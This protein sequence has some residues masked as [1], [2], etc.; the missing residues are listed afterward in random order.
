MGYTVFSIG[1]VLGLAAIGLVVIGLLAP[2]L[3]VVSGVDLGSRHRK[4][5]SQEGV[6][7]S[8][9]RIVLFWSDGQFSVRDGGAVL[10]DQRVISYEAQEDGELW[11]RAAAYEDIL[12]VQIQQD[13]S[14][15][16][17]SLISVTTL[18]GEGFYLLV[19]T[20][21]DGDERMLREIRKRLDVGL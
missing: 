20:E 19:T 14:S 1:G 3:L 16:L 15:E 11:I 4:V 5:L 13:K 9:E 18:G 8:G 21:E 6:I 17:A 2:P 10:T 12:D 7:T